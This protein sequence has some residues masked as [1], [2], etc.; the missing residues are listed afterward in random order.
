MVADNG[1]RNQITATMDSPGMVPRH[2]AAVCSGVLTTK[3]SNAITPHAIA[4]ASMNFP[5]SRH[6]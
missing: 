1:D 5:D 6:S 2:K 4:Y 3:I